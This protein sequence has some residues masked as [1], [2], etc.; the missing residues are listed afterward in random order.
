M[1]NGTDDLVAFPPERNEA[2]WTRAN[3]EGL[4]NLVSHPTYLR[5]LRALIAGGKLSAA[6]DSV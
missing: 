6:H 5:Y 2:Y 1:N 3:P 4:P